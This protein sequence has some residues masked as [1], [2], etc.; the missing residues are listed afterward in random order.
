MK[1]KNKVLKL[2]AMLLPM[3]MLLS[4]CGQTAESVQSSETAKS[5]SSVE[6]E[7]SS[8]EVTAPETE[9]PEYLNMDS[10]YPIIK[11]EYEDDITLTMVI[12]MKE[13]SGAWDDL[14]ISKYLSDKYNVNIDVEYVTDSTLSERKNLMYAANE[15]PDIMVNCYVYTEELVKYGV[16]EG[17]F[18][19]LDSY[20]NET[21]TPN[22][23][24]YMVDD[25]KAVCTATDG[26]I[27]TLPYLQNAEEP[28]N[29]IPARMFINSAW[30][31][32]LGLELPRT[33]DEF[34][35]ALYAIKEADP[36]GVGS[37]NLYPMGGGMDTSSNPRYLLNALGYIA[38]N[39]DNY[40]LNP[41]LRDG[42]V[43]IPAYDMDVFQEYLK[44]M[45]QF[46]TDGII[47]PTFFTMD[48]TE[49]NAQMVAEQT[50]M[51]SNAPYLPGN[52]NWADFECLY[53][54]TSEW[55]TE[56]E[57]AKVSA[58]SIGGFVI[59]ADTE[60]PELCLRLADAFFNNTDDYCAALYG[61]YGIDSEYSYGYLQKE[62][63]PE[64]NS[65]AVDSNKTPGNISSWNYIVQ[66]V[67][68]NTWNFGATLLP[69]SV[70][71][72]VALQGNPD[73]KEKLDTSGQN[74]W[75]A[76]LGEHMSPYAVDGFPTTLY[77]SADISQQI[78]DL[79]TVINPY[80][81]EQIALFI[82]GKRDLSE[83][84]T[85]KEELKK[86]GMEDLLNIYKEQYAAYIQQ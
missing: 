16:E 19:Q 82:T 13:D 77:L 64:S 70:E 58:A 55:Q 32:E 31:Q 71:K 67:N 4:A 80:V 62:Y 8:E 78:T 83:V 48:S 63:L 24:K 38:Y 18:L 1:M 75:R 52:E 5:E 7:T 53:P 44:L 43:V 20:M 40:G 15:L 10:A 37:E 74:I 81:Q 27:Y 12:G 36:S 61:G 28:N 9:Y 42:E 25:V 56:P 33:L 2:F 79:K 39:I 49:V 22:I 60:Y 59:S 65:F 35:D 50:A 69:E 73:Y 21:L 84:D 6:K 41:A 29:N 54:L 47:A 68:G 51:Y 26:H 11:D 45:N 46:Y 76:S 3:T 72:L 86:M 34:V 57:I 23:L 85:F 66:Y 14:W 30:L 17:M